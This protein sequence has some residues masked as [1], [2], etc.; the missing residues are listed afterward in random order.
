V[1]TFTVDQLTVRVHDDIPDLAADAAVVARHAIVAAIDARG[2]AH[3]MFASGT[4]QLAF[5]AALVDGGGVDWTR[6][7]GFH[8]DDYVGI[9]ADHPA[10]FARYMREHITSVVPV[11]TFHEIQGDAPDTSAEVARYAALLHDHPLDLCCLGIGENGHLAFNDPPPGGADFAD[12]ATVKIVTLDE[13]CK[14]QQVGE[15]H[16]ATTADVPPTAIT[17]T[18]PGLLAAAHVL[19]V[20]P[21]ARKAAAV[22]AALDGPIAP[23]CPASALRTHGAATL[24]LDRDSAASVHAG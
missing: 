5:L 1:R 15:G 9:G 7:T 19:A 10:S 17:V 23:A 12:P 4:S 8:M 18:I 13:Q 14:Q 11:G 20:V 16:F 3:V 21:E 6:V 22:G 2:G 24:L